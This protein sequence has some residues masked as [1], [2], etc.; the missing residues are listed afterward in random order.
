M[1]ISGSTFSGNRSKGVGGGLSN[2]GTTLLSNDTISGNYADESDAGLYNSSTSVASLNNLTIVN[3]RADYDVNGVGQGGG[4]FIEAG[5]VNIYNTIIAQNTDS[6]LVQHPDCDGSVATSTYNL[7]Q[8]TSGCTL[9]GSPIG[10]VTG[11]SPQIGPLT[12]NGGSTRTHA[13]LPNSPAL[14]AGRLYANGAFN[15]CEATDQRNL[16]RAPGGRCDIG[17]Y[18]SG[19]AIQLFLPIVVR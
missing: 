15:N 13:L 5:T 19:A 3:N 10:N 16:P 12:N 11:Q 18:E 2:A 8:N 7:I 14:N 1:T 4:I 17:A 9:Q 6:V